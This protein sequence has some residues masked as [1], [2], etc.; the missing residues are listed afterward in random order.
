MTTVTT[1]IAAVQK[2]IEY[3][4]DLIPDLQPFIDS[5]IVLVTA[6]VAVSPAPSDEIL[7]L[8]CRYL[9]SHLVKITDKEILSEQVKSL[10]QSYA[11][12][13]G[14]GL[15]T[16]HFGQMAMLFDVTGRLARWNARNVEGTGTVQFFWAGTE[17]T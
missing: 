3:D 4:T 16:S 8:V 2:I 7:E 17:A 13:L 5:A 11:L 9:T 14:L 12:K 15:A 1:T 6:V 10:Q